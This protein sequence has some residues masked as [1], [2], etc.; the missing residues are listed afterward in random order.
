MI[1]IELTRKQLDQAQLLINATDPGIYRLKDL[2]G[3]N[4]AAIPAKNNFGR[5]FL[6]S[7]ERHLLTSI[8]SLNKTDQNH[9]TYKIK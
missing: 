5:N 6:Y 2:Y 7:A 3:I 4:W 8:I 9:Q 1:K